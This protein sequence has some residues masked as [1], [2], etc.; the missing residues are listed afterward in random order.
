MP[1]DDAQIEEVTESIWDSILGLKVTPAEPDRLSG[2]DDRFLTACVQITGEWAGA[3]TLD[4]PTAF[5]RR[6]AQIMFESEPDEIEL[7]DLEDALGE[8]ANMLGGNIKNLLPGSSQ[9]SL[10]AVTEGRDY[11]VSV[12]GSEM[13]N[14]VGFKTEG[15][16]ITISVLK[17][18]TSSK[19]RRRAEADSAAG[20]AEDAL[21]TNGS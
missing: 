14:H 2:G 7:E 5:A 15:Y 12:P 11:T 17:R 10:P 4:C 8:L 9:L 19:G 21:E 3:V 18:A 20:Q 16:P 1:I 13:V 6:A